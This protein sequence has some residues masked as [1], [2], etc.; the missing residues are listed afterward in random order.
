MPALAGPKCWYHTSGESRPMQRTPVHLFCRLIVLKRLAEIEGWWGPWRQRG[1]TLLPKAPPSRQ[2]CPAP[3]SPRA[4]IYPLPFPFPMAEQKTLL[5]QT[6]Q[7]RSGVVGALMQCAARG[8]GGSARWRDWVG[9]G[10]SCS[11][12]AAG[13]LPCWRLP[14]PRLHRRRPSSMVAF[15]SLS[16]CS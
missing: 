8:R 11:P 10:R 4:N 7:S 16:G 15:W 2:R 6:I 14:A 1:G 9:M 3:V 13:V 5:K 12:H